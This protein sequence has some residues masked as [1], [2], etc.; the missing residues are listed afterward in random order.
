MRNA[1][2]GRCRRLLPRTTA[3]VSEDCGCLGLLPL[4]PPWLLPLSL[5]LILSLLLPSVSAA[6]IATF[7]EIG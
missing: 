7:E 3:A 4:S 1:D 2:V 5:H 6:E